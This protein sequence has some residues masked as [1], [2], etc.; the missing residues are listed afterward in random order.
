MGSGV[1]KRLRILRPYYEGVGF[2]KS[3]KV[4]VLTGELVLDLDE[5]ENLHAFIMP[6]GWPNKPE[7]K[8]RALDAVDS[9]SYAFKALQVLGVC[10]HCGKK[11]VQG[12][13]RGRTDE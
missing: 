7:Q 13:Q 5:V 6:N 10:P 4:D 3:L 2:T 12:G 9:R 8:K 11:L 1:W